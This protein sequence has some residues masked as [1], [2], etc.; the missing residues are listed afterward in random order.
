[1]A[2]DRAMKKILSFWEFINTSQV[3]LSTMFS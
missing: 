1:L 2:V 3:V